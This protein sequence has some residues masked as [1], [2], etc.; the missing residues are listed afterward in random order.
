MYVSDYYFA[1][2]IVTSG[3]YA[4]TSAIFDWE[5]SSADTYAYSVNN[6]CY[7]GIRY[8]NC[9]T[10]YGT[11]GSPGGA[12]YF[13]LFQSE[14]M[15]SSFNVITG[16]SGETGPYNANAF[17][18]TAYASGGSVGVPY[19]T[20]YP[21]PSWAIGRLPSSGINSLNTFTPVYLVPNMNYYRYNTGTTKELAMR[22]KFPNL[23]RTSDNIG[24]PGDTLNYGGVDYMVLVLHKTGGVSINDAYNSLNACY[25]VP[26]LINGK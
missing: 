13:G 8:F 11:I 16:Q 12:D 15:N 10:G 2:T 20:L 1:M 26:K 6:L 23:Y 17:F 3:S 9:S 19:A 21:N 14:Y 24:S 7:P 18:G 4:T 5:I 22:A 25:L